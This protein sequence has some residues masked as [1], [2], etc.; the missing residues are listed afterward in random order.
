MAG[1]TKIEWTD[2]TWNPVRGCTKISPGCKH[3][4]AERFAERFRGVK[5]HPFEQGFDLRLVPEKLAEPLRWPEPRMIFVNSMSDLFHEDIP[6]EFVARVAATMHV[7][8]WHTY[9][10]LTKRSGRMR[11]LLNGPLHDVAIEPHIWWGVSVENQQYG[12]PR[13]ADLQATPA[14][15]RFLS[16]EPLLEDLGRLPL[17]GI[18]WVIVGGESGPGARPMQESWVLS[19]REQCEAAGVAFFFKQW[20]GVRKKV[21]G[22]KLLGRTFDA[23][24]KRVQHPTLPVSVRLQH[25]LR[26]ESSPLVQLTTA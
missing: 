13:I 11:E 5:G 21:R 18:S 4:Y 7:A 26:I 1:L 17:D 3:C 23:I 6:P 20:G 12:I 2:A 14:A 19:I 25:A 16:V 24:P 8:R 22:R 9:Q 10:V 15:V